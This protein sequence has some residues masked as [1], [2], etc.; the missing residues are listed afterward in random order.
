LIGDLRPLSGQILF[1]GID[2][3]DWHLW[4][5]R[6]L[7]GLLPAESGFLHGTPEEN[8]VFGR[9]RA[10]VP[11]LE[12]ALEASGVAAMAEQWDG[13]MQRLLTD[14]YSE[15]AGGQRRRIALARLLAGDQRAWVL[16][17]PGP[18]LDPRSM[19]GRTSIIITD[20]NLFLQNGQIVD[21]GTHEELKRRN[22]DYSQL[23]LA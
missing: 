20:S 8:V 5:R 21:Q 2:I 4:W 22:P 15:L 12:W 23:V 1:D 11:N 16:D 3:A 6:E 17:E 19:K 13:G 9:D 14:P 18:Q 10:S 7:I